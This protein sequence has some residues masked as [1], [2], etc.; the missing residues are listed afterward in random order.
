M[1]LIYINISSQTH[2]EIQ[3]R[4]DTEDTAMIIF[5]ISQRKHYVV[6]PY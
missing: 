4:G 2:T 3:V 6:T 1:G 5:L